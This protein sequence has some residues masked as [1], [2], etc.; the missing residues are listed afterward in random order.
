MRL[1]QKR[2]EEAALR[3]LQE[4]VGLHVEES[5]EEVMEREERTQALAAETARLE[6]ERR[7]GHDDKE[8]AFDRLLE[9][10]EAAER[11]ARAAERE[12]KVRKLKEREAERAAKK[13]RR[14]AAAKQEKEAEEEEEEEEE[15]ARGAKEEVREVEEDLAEEE[16]LEERLRWWRRLGRFFV[17]TWIKIR[18]GRGSPEEREAVH[19]LLRASGGAGGVSKKKN[20]AGA[21]GGSGQRRKGRRRDS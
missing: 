6:R 5:P 15:R 17:N 11:V 7:K 9:Q 13:N 14:A 8:A 1:K 3:A 21:G 10:S 16:S 18:R 20:G 2:E 4:G 19:A 12:E